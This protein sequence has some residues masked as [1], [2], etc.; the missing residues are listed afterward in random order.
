MTECLG[1]VLL[2][3]LLDVESGSCATM[4]LRSEPQPA[5]KKRSQ[6]LMGHARNNWIHFWQLKIIGHRWLN[7]DHSFFGVSV[8]ITIW[9]DDGRTTMMHVCLLASFGNRV[10]I[11]ARESAVGSGK[12]IGR[13]VLQPILSRTKHPSIHSTTSPSSCSS[14]PRKSP[15]NYA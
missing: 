11:T 4:A 5:Q 1:T 3:C 9:S 6:R 12:W 2:S 14:F 13:D 8:L 7:T 15:Q 10:A